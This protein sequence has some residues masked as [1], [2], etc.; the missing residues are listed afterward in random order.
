MISAHAMEGEEM[1]AVMKDFEDHKKA[2]TQQSG[3]MH[4][5]LPPPFQDKLNIP[6][7]VD[8]GE[9]TITK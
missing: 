4:F 7:K 6:G 8:R 5:D 9:L 1:R 2:F 3:D